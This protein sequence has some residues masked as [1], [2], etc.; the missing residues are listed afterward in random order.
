MSK[1]LDRVVMHILAK[2]RTLSARRAT[3][4][5]WLYVAVFC[6][7]HVYVDA[8]KGATYVTAVGMM[9]ALYLGHWI[10]YHRGYNRG[11]IGGLFRRNQFVNEEEEE[12][13]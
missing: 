7:F 9:G 8:E 6:L 4:I 5:H 13:K 11:Y 12:K 1:F 2:E 10:G 3:V